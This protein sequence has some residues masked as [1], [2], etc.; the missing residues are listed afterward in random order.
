[1]ARSHEGLFKNQRAKSKF[2][3]ID[4]DKMS[5]QSISIFRDQRFRARPFPMSFLNINT[6]Q[7]HSAGRLLQPINEFPE[8]LVLRQQDATFHKAFCKTSSS[9]M[10]ACCSGT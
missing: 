6:N 4:Y 2:V 5:R 10:P 8:I 1:M 9:E 3:Q 7:N